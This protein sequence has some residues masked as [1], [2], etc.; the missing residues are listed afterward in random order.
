PTLSSGPDNM[1]IRAA[2][3]LQE[4]AGCRQGARIRLVKRIPRQAGLGGGSSDAAATLGGLDQLWRL[5][6]ATTNLADLGAPPGSDVPI[7]FH[8]PAAWCPGRGER[9]EPLCPGRPLQLVLVCPSV[10][11]STAE[12]YANLGQ[13]LQPHQPLG[14]G[15]PDR[16]DAIRQAFTA[17][18]I[19][20]LG[21]LLF[22]ALH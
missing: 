16:Q 8:T 1:V 10:G 18:R 12:V 6:L 7:F 2:R 20:E 14:A 9:I 22:N 15:R 11:L 13:V 19:D 17:G 4:Q 3:L 5:G 21:R